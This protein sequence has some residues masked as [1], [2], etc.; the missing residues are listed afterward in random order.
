M[1]IVDF[2]FNY[3]VVFLVVLTIL[4]FVHEWGHYWVA[5]RAGVR[6]EVF[7]IG[8]GPEIYGWT[9]KHD[10]RWKISAIP[11]GGYVKMFGEADMGWEEEEEAEPLPP[12]EK[13][14]SFH[15]KKLWQRSAIVAAGPIANFVFASVL[16]A[17]LAGIVGTARPLAAVG[18]VQPGSAAAAAQ[19]QAGDRI[20]AIDGQ[21]I[22]WFEDLRRIVSAKP[23]VPLSMEILRGAETLT[24]TVTP[25][26]HVLKD[27]KAPVG[28]L[29]VRF[30]PQAVEYERQGPVEAVSTGVGYTVDMVA[31]IFGVLGEMIAGHRS[32]EELGGPLR[33]AQ[34]SGDIAQLGFKELVLF[35]AAL[36]VNLGL[37]NLF[38]VPVLDGGRLVFYAAEGLRG[39]PVAPKIEEYG[40][41]LGL[42]LVLFLVVFVTWNDITQMPWDRVFAWFKG[43]I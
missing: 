10:T 1:N 11:L 5:R 41:R 20:A 15:H 14:V 25:R 29:G 26:S 23:G 2:A 17:L 36:S 34:L 3:V 42:A 16:V 39:R 27:A 8:F 18:E 7:S 31:R 30:D 4:V 38:P 24:V 32:A 19:L 35:M 28:L 13:A 37:I 33:I 43:L 12:E 40:M 9:D 22:K 21:P 6:V